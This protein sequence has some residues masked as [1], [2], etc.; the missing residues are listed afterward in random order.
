MGFYRL[1]V[2]G[3]SLGLLGLLSCKG[4]PGPGL[5]LQVAESASQHS[6]IKT[7]KSGFPLSAVLREGSVRLSVL[8]KQGQSWQFQ[9]DLTAKLPDEH[10]SIDLGA[11]D[12]NQGKTRAHAICHH[13][14]A[15]PEIVQ[16]LR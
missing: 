2:V 8:Q 13:F 14:S 9:C 10:P 15:L 12:R 5:K 7:D 3:L 4:N 1:R 6:C 11:I 16:R